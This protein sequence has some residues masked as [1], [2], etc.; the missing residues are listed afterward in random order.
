MSSSSSLNISFSFEYMV[1]IIVV[2]V[3]CNMLVKRSPQMNTIIV[4]VAGLF[5]GYITLYVMNN[6]FPYMN[7]LAYSIYQY[8]V[9]K[10]TS[11]YT[12]MGYM[13]I[14]PPILA[15]LIIFIILLYNRQLG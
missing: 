8:Y 3:V 5:I 9:Y 7:Q 13:H 6:F 2:I 15:V 14:W 10:I 4:V 1:S 12:S 11:S